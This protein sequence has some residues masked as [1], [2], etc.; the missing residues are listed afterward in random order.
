VTP[1][2]TALATVV[3]LLARLGVPYMLTGSMATSYYGRPR[4]THDADLVIDPSFTQLEALIGALTTAGFYVSGETARNALRG[5]RPFN[6]IEMESASKIDFI[7]RRDRA[8]SRTEF[9]RRTV[10]DLPFG[11]GVSIVSPEDAVLS[12][13]E[14]ARRSG[15]SERQLADAAGVVDLNPD[16][17]RDYITQWAEELGV[18][19]LWRRIS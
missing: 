3:S 12:K 7:V 10:A 6:A 14:W 8:F 5:G 11:N 15:D 16:L 1:E 19:D 4:A 13:L 17:D 9:T 2:E 18:T